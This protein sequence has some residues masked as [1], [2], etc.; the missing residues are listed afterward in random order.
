MKKLVGIGLVLCMV[1]FASVGI[2]LGVTVYAKSREIN[3]RIENGPIKMAVKTTARTVRD[4]LEQ[5]KVRLG[6][7]D[8]V[9]PAP[10]TRLSDGMVVVVNRAMLVYIRSGGKMMAPFYINSGTVEDA[11]LQA[12]ISFDQDDEISPALDTALSAGM[13]IKHVARETVIE[14]ELQNIKYKTVYEKTNSLLKGKTQVKQSGK[15]GVNQKMVEV[16]YQDGVEVSRKVINTIPKQAP[17]DRI[18]LKG[19]GVAA[20]PTGGGSSGGSSSGGSSGGS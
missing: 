10:N 11:L 14:T 13:R 3:V 5:S 7:K 18:I 2:L 17:M 20:K 19:T 9:M 12:K 16:I 8:E 6:P 1:L 15:Q 4:V